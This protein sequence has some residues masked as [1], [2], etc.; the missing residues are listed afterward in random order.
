MIAGVSACR[1]TTGNHRRP[2]FVISFHVRAT[3]DFLLNIGPKQD[4]SIPEESVKVLTEVG[5]WMQKYNGHA[6]YQS[7]LWVPLELCKL[8]PDRQ[9]ALH[10]CAFL[11]WRD[12]SPQ[13]E[14][15]V[16]SVKL[17]KTGAALKFSQDDFRVRVL[18]SP[19]EGS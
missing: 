17:V 3:E 18:E 6:V 9:Y 5:S 13:L 10:A 4:G 14:T 7:D 15:K 16:K 11:A 19:S 1:M 8:Y 12:M 2:S